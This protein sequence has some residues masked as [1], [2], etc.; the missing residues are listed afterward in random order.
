MNRI[1]LWLL[2]LLLGQNKVDKTTKVDKLIL[3]SICELMFEDFKK[4]AAEYSGRLMKDLT[5]DQLQHI[6][7]ANTKLSDMQ[8]QA[9]LATL[10]TDS[11]V[12]DAYR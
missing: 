10:N 12:P 8:R 2:R 7:S 11:A 3:H 6:I 4:C 1:R 9:M 5:V